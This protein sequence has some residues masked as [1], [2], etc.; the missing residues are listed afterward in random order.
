MKH[1]TRI[2]LVNLK[3][4]NLTEAGV[5]DPEEVRRITV[6]NAVVDTGASQL[7]LPKSLVEQL[8]L[9]P[10]GSRKGQTT[11]GIVDRFIYS[12]VQFTVLERSGIIEVTDIPE[13]VPVLVGHMILEMLDLCLDI[14]KGLI[15]NPDH[16]DEWIEDQL[17]LIR[18]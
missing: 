17:L 11:N 10:V 7:S 18:N 13:N 6:E 14:K 2:E 9:T 4:L 15:Y 3:D 8:G 12:P 1:T 5:I 16:D